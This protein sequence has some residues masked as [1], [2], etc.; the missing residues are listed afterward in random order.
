[1]TIWG[2]EKFISLYKICTTYLVRCRRYDTVS[3]IKEEISRG[4]EWR[5]LRGK[6]RIYIRTGD[7][8]GIWIWGTYK[9]IDHDTHTV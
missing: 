4:P 5:K 2:V 8:G 1:M 9:Y 6:K 7:C 3:I